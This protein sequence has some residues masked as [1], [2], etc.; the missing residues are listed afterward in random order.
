LAELRA[1][2]D[3][4]ERMAAQHREQR[5]RREGVAQLGLESGVLVAIPGTEP[6]G[7]ARALAR[8]IGD[9]VA[10]HAARLAEPIERFAIV[11]ARAREGVRWALEGPDTGLVRELRRR[12]TVRFEWPTA[13]PPSEDSLLAWAAIAGAQALLDHLI[14]YDEPLQR[15]LEWRYELHWSARE[16]NR[17]VVAELLYGP[18]TR[19]RECLAGDGLACA[20]W[21]G[22][23]EGASAVRERYTPAEA[24]RLARPAEWAR[25]SS[26][27][28]ACGQGDVEA[29]YRQLVGVEVPASLGARRSFLAFVRARYGREAMAAVLADRSAIGA[30]V[31]AAT[32]AGLEELGREWREWLLRETRWQ[33]VRAGM[34][35][36]L[37]T[38]LLVGVL[39]TMAGR[40]GRWRA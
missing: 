34:R 22:L 20:R 37:P 14:R 11:D 23:N 32:G 28:E 39:V 15:W 13:G 12:T 25:A 40:S 26:H 3:R 5:R 21:L 18:W 27:Q 33:P 29:C 10:S 35:E 38:L 4:A 19:G 31:T 36:L 30:R 2:L 6:A 8:A 24:R 17:S 9:T 16:S 1:R 7:R